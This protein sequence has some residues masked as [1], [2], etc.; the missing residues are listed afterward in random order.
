MAAATR[1]QDRWTAGGQMMHGV[2]PQ[3]WARIVEMSQFERDNRDVLEACRKAAAKAGKDQTCRAI[4][5][6]R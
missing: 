5:R 1:K 3:D 2:S 6:R 4:V